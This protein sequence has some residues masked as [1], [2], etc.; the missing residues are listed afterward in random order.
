MKYSRSYEVWYELRKYP[1]PK[2]LKKE[3]DMFMEA[4]EMSDIGDDYSTLADI[5]FVVL[6]VI[7]FLIGLGIGLFIC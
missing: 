3:M 7:I 5:V 4:D 2:H 1:I 6:M